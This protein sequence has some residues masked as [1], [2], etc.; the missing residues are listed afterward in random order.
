VFFLLYIYIFVGFFLIVGFPN[1]DYAE[2]II[3][4]TRG[5]LLCH[6]D[7]GFVLLQVKKYYQYYTW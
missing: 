6:H 2:E 3:H 7:D 4:W 5:F 1:F